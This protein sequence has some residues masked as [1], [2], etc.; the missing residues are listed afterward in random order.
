MLS[1]LIP[2]YNIDPASKDPY[3]TYTLWFLVGFLGAHSFYLRDWWRGVVYVIDFALLVHML[4][5]MFSTVF[6]MA[7]GS[8]VLPLITWELATPYMI[9]AGIMLIVHVLVTLMWIVDGVRITK[10]INPRF[11]LENQ[12][13]GH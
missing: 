3:L 13:E 9:Y 10:H 7:S 5:V 2:P 11:T 12:T 1:K 4:W 6:R 8:L